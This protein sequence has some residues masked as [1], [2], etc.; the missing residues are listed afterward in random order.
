[1]IGDRSLT[2]SALQMIHSHSIT[3]AIDIVIKNFTDFFFGFNFNLF[4]LTAE[5]D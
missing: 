2:P 5:L 3:V 1:M 4:S